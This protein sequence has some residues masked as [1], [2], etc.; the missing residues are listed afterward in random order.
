VVDPGRFQRV[1]LRTTRLTLAVELVDAETTS[2][3]GAGPTVRIVG[4][5]A[6][7]VRNKS[8]YR[9]F[10][11]VPNE[12]VTLAVAGGLEYE[13]VRVEGVNLSALEPREPSLTVPLTPR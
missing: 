8:N 11:D 5:P 1:P 6:E 9:L 10:F 12:T 13:D 4:W 2:R 7:G 3:I